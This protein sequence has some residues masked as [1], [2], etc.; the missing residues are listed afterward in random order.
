VFAEE[1]CYLQEFCK[2]QNALANHRTAF[3]QQRSLVRSQHR[4]LDKRL[5]L[6]VKRKLQ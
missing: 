6:Q 1:N 5:H 4:P 2:L 3:T